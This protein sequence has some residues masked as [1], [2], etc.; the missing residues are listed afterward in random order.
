MSGSG[1]IGNG[2]VERYLTCMAA[3]DWAGSATAAKRG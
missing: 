2:A 3:H 1:E